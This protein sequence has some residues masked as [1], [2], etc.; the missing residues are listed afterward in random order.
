MWPLAVAELRDLDARN[1][2]GTTLLYGAKDE[3]V[4]HARIL[5]D[6]LAAPTLP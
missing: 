2:T 3:R 6:Y 5:A 1:P 4:N